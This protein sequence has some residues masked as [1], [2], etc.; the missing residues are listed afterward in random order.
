FNVA[1][2]GLPPAT[3][4][5]GS[6]AALISRAEIIG[7]VVETQNVT[8]CPNCYCTRT[9]S[10][11]ESSAFFTA[12]TATDSG[13]PFNEGRQFVSAPAET[14]NSETELVAPVWGV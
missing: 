12:V 5:S 11:S 3:D 4:A 14:V 7:V 1:R 8:E 2:R 10:S 13:C 6:S 9:T